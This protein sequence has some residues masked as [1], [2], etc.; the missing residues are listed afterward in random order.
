MLGAQDGCLGHHGVVRTSCL[1]EASGVTPG[2]L[3]GQHSLSRCGH[4][5]ASPNATFV[6]GFISH[7]QTHISQERKTDV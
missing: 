4:R 5:L 6:T 7:R 3:R 2:A 1:D